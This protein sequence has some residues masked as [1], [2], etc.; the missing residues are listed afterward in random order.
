[1]VQTSFEG[2]EFLDGPLHERAG[3]EEPDHPRSARAALLALNG[4]AC[5]TIK[6]VPGSCGPLP[7]RSPVLAP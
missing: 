5:V 6:N 2:A 1:M 4:L 7:I 3:V